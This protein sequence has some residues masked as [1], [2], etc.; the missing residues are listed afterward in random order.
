MA[1]RAI[2]IILDSVGIGELPDAHLFG[3]QGSDTLGNLSRTFPDGLRLPNMGRLGLGNIAPLRGVDPDPAAIGGWG[4]CT[5]QS[6]AKDTTLGHWELAGIISREPFLTFLN[7]FPREIL[8]PFERDIGA[9][10]IGNCVASGTEGI[11]R[12]GDEHVATGTP[13]AS[14][15]P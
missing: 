11:Q 12:L 3:D 13:I 6:A 14:T 1:K 15:S 2:I 4:K 8:D 10:S 5:E 7:G 9:G